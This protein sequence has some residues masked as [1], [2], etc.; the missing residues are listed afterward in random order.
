MPT[1][2]I[3]CALPLEANALPS[4]HPILTTGPGFRHARTALLQH[5]ATHRPSHV[6]S[7]GTC[8]ALDPAL[9]LGQVLTVSKIQSSLGTFHPIPLNSPHAVLHSQDAVAVTRADK[10][11]LHQQG[12]QIVDM[13]AAALAEV[14]AAH[15]IPFSCLKAVSDTALEN[16][17]LDLNRY[18]DP[19]GGFRTAR[20]AFAGIMKIT[21]LLRLQR[22][23]KFAAK[24][25]G[26]ALANALKP[27]T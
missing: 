15:K 19:Q 25:L 7:V 20:I 4:I 12:A 23:S 26:E 14:C 10:Q 3:L 16:L 24:Q 6:L 17:P 2:L 21:A 5:L 22:Q 11:F 27:L 8:G 9:V 13:E 18:R 1:P